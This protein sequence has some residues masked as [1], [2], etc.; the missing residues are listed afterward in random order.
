MSPKAEDHVPD[1]AQLAEV[2]DQA[3]LAEVEGLCQALL[4]Q[5]DQLLVQLQLQQQDFRAEF[6][7]SKPV[8][9][10]G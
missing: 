6:G 8:A 2:P 5:Q 1:K 4:K 9:G 10:E 7:A 3:Q